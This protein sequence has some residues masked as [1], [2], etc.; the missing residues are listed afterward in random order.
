MTPEAA[1]TAPRANVSRLWARWVVSNLSPIPPNT[2]VCSP[3][4]SPART[5]NTPISFRVRSPTI[6]RRPYTP[7]S[8][9]SRPSAPATAS[10]SFTAVPEGESFLNRWWVS[11]ISTSE[12]S[13]STRATSAATRNIRFPH[14]LMLGERTHAIVSAAAR[15][16]PVCSFVK[17]VLPITIGL[18]AAAASFA[19]A[20]DE[21]AWVKSIATSARAIDEGKSLVT[22]TSAFPAPA[23][24]KA[25]C[26]SSGWPGVSSAPERT[27]PFGR[28]LRIP[29]IARPILPIAPHT[30]TL[31]MLFFLPLSPSGEFHVGKNLGESL[32][33]RLRHRGKGKPELLVDPPHHGQG[34][35]C[36]DGVGLDEQRVEQRPQLV[37]DVPRA[38]DLAEDIGV[39]QI[40]H[41]PG[42][43][44]RR[45]GDHPLRAKR[46]HGKEQGIVAGEDAELLRRHPDDVAHLGQVAGSLLPPH[47]GRDLGQAGHGGRRHVHPGPP[48]H[49]VED[50]RDVGRLGDSAEVPD[51]TLLRR[52]VV[53]RRDDECRA[54]PRPFRVPGENDR[55]LRV[56]GAGPCDH[57]DAA[58]RRFENGVD[59]AFV[60]VEGKCRRFPGRPARDD[61]VRAVVDLE[62]HELPQRP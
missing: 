44:V 13:R 16:S 23:A 28:S 51:E 9:M 53:V 4:T 24:S 46:H 19:G 60:L 32:P 54:C 57:R 29:R 55:L 36:G 27:S 15:I 35:L 47:D 50:D 11:T 30:T 40:R 48:R 7:A 45:H 41:Q 31:A 43:N 49:V 25:S 42:G 20:T 52:L 56:V 62:C 12:S 14:T 1:L 17:P 8:F 22:A 6:P 33:V 10:A 18:P 59:D 34:R 26:P 38:G 5:A 2:R 3:T 58:V 21:T 61:P 39:V 37:M